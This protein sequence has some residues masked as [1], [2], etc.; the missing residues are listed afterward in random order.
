LADLVRVLV[1]EHRTMKD[2]LRRAQ[3]A[4]REGDFEA[5]GRALKELDPV[6]RQHIADEEA[7]ILGLLIKTLGVKGAEAEIIVFRQHR[8]IY[9]LMQKVGELAKKSPSQLHSSQ[10]ELESLFEEHTLAE[11]GRVFP[12]ALGLSSAGSGGH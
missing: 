3:D 11:E 8:P 5:V 1:D 2:G 7:T 12:R 9:Q 10:S 4:A 6:F